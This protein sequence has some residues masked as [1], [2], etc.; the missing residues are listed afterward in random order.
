MAGRAFAAE[1]APGEDREVTEDVPNP[2]RARK[3]FRGNL[4]HPLSCES[5]KPWTGGLGEVGKLL[6]YTPWRQNASV[7]L[8]NL[9]NDKKDTG[10]MGKINWQLISNRCD[11]TEPL[12][13]VP[14][15][16]SPRRLP[17]EDGCLPLPTPCPG[18]AGLSVLLPDRHPNRHP[19]RH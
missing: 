4:H 17:M 3:I 6:D 14:V 15:H 2:L 13:M 11:A 1:D 10:S 19:Q 7:G 16:G 18:N 8:F 5:Q 9:P 12:W